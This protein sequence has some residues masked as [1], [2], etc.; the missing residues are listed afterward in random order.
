MVFREK[1]QTLHCGA[2]KLKI[3]GLGGSLQLWGL[4][5]SS[6]PP[7]HGSYSHPSIVLVQ[8]HSHGGG[9]LRGANAPRGCALPQQGCQTRPPPQCWWWSSGF[10]LFL[11]PFTGKKADVPR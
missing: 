2:A 11:P 5:P 4:C 8:A 10:N 7:T 9:E 6:F 1:E 3:L